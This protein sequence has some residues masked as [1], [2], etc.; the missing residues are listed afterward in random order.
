MKPLIVLLK[1]SSSGYPSLLQAL[2]P[3]TP[4]VIQNK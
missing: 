1:I 3:K 4:K 2:L